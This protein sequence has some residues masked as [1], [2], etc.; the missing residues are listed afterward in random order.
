MEPLAGKYFN[1]PRS[2]GDGF[3]GNVKHNT[4]YQN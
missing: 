4:F 3:E 2:F 1:T